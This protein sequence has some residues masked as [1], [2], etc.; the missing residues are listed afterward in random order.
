MCLKYASANMKDNK[1]V[2]T[3]AAPKDAMSLEYASADMKK[4]DTA[5]L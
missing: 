3:A 2:V 5:G 4:N 1:K